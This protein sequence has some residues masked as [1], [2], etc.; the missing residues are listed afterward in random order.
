VSNTA[1]VFVVVGQVGQVDQVVVRVVGLAIQALVICLHSPSYPPI[2]RGLSFYTTIA[3]HFARVISLSFGSESEKA[4]ARESEKS[5]KERVRSDVSNDPLTHSHPPTPTQ[6]RE[7]NED[8][9]WTYKDADM[10]NCK[11][12]KEKSRTLWTKKSQTHFHKHDATDAQ[13][14]KSSDVPHHLADGCSA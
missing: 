14:D 2:V 3:T 6:A 9:K 4:C 13:A 1:L 12:K 10:H 11:K 5:E 8:K 7:Q